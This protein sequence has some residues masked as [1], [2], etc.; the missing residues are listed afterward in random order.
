M[1]KIKKLLKE[2]WIFILGFVLAILYIYSR[3]IFNGE[4]LSFTNMLYN[5]SPWNSY[6]VETSGPLLSDVAD[7]L[8]PTIYKVFYTGDWFSLWNSNVS[9]GVS[10]DMS[11]ILYPLNY[12]YLLPIGIAIIAKSILEFTIGFTGM[13]FLMRELKVN[14][15]SATI[16][17]IIYT[18]SSALVMWHGWA[19]SDVAIFGPFLFLCIIKFINEIKIKYVFLFSIILYIML[20]AGMPT[21]AAYFM[22]LLGL[23][24]L[25]ITIKKYWKEKRK[26][27]IIFLS[28]SVG[29]II[30][31]LITLPYTGNI[32]FTVG[33]NGYSESRVNQGTLTLPLEY[34]RMIIYPYIRTGLQGHINETTIYC[35]II[36]I[37]LMLFTFVKYKDK[38][39]INFWCIAWIVLALIIF[40]HMFDGIFTKL[41]A[42]NTSR[43]Y[44]I[45]VLFNFVTAIISGLNLNHIIEN[46]DYYKKRFRYILG[47]AIACFGIVW[48]ITKSLFNYDV[49]NTEVQDTIIKVCILFTLILIL[50]WIVIRKNSKIAMGLLI[51]VVLFDMG[52][53]AKEYFPYIEKG[54]KIIPEATDTIKYLQDNLD[55]NERFTALG[56]WTLFANTNI[57]YGIDDIRSHSFINTNEDVFNYFSLIDDEI[58]ASKTRVNIL[59]IDNYNLVK[60][61][62]VKYIASEGTVNK[63]YTYSNSNGNTQTVGK[64]TDNVVVKQEFI[65]TEDELTSIDFLMA[66]YGKVI[67]SNDIIKVS[68]IDSENNTIRSKEIKL[69]EINDNEF[70][71]VEF[72]PINNSK[73]E[74]FTIKLTSTANQENA[75]TLWNAVDNIYTGNLYINNELAEGDLII[76]V[77][78][79]IPEVELVFK[80]N[81]GLCVGQ[82]DEYSPFIQLIENV[83]VRKNADEVLD[84]MSKEY[85]NNTLFLNEEEVEDS[86]VNV[87]KDSFLSEDEYFEVIENDDDY[88]KIKVNIEQPRY[89]LLN[90]YYSQGWKVYIDGKEE[91]LLKSN[92]LMK[93]VYLED[94]GEHIVEFKYE[95]QTI[96]NFIYIALGAL[97]VFIIIFIFRNKIQKYIDK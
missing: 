1:N 71:H 5:F 74:K 91:T 68:I 37:V 22:Y 95:P 80:G 58:F 69:S 52:S 6:G 86:K 77:G 57:F 13:Y 97:G 10:E 64:I 73:G 61:L 32:L 20:T 43:K 44:R 36:S 75:I 19:H 31:V 70:Y 93:S 45:I 54:S 85:L 33:S 35:G 42:I 41:P 49:I 3:Q 88:K 72:F 29:V 25:I 87:Y 76:K 23:Y 15:V 39:G 53:F 89:L 27:F 60:Y 2:N 18:F 21:Y 46:R 90:E 94:S 28:F 14:K 24:V 8:L 26:I 67:N 78:Y 17:G 79:N 48:I 9:I 47:V 4:S 66:N 65:A 12:I 82:L 62:G 16:S 63:V 92:Y 59:D 30:S 96:Y 7:N 83:E 38:K 34:I 11:V 50:L 84:S 51:T 40:T 56:D 55:D 81:D